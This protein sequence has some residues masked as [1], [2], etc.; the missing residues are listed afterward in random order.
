VPD[1]T[2]EP[3]PAPGADQ[4]LAPGPDQAPDGEVLEFAAEFRR[5]LDWVRSSAAGADRHNEVSALVRGFLGPDGVEHSVVNRD[6]PPFEHVNLQ[7]AINAWLTRPGRT[8]EIR[9]ISV[10]PHYGGLTLQQLVAQD[11]LP[12][13]RLTAPALADLPNGPGSTLACLKL[14]VLLITDEP[15]GG[16]PGGRYVVMIQAQSEHRPVIEVEVAGLPVAAAQSLLAELDRLRAELNVYRGHLL[17]VSLSAMGGISLAF[18]DPP[19]LVREDVV[20]PATVLARVERHA[21]G[22]A[23]HRDALLAAGQHL[24]RGLL[25]YG[26]PGTGKTHTTRYLLGQMN[27]YTR[28]VLTGRSLVAVGQVADLARALVPAVVVLE[29][30]D[31]VA[32]E[33]SM[34]PASSPVL[35]DLLDAMDGAAPDA[36]VL[37]LL[38]TNRADL[39]ESA[40]AA[41]PGRVDVA[42]E[43]ALPD[44]PARQRLL[45]LYSRGVPM[46][47]TADEVTAAVERTDGTTA[48]FIKELIR[49]SVLEALHDNPPRQVPAAGAPEPGSAAAGTPAS[50]SPAL[51]AVTGAHLTRALDDL[52]DT[53]QAVTRTLLGVGVNPEDLPAGGALAAGPAASSM[54]AMMARRAFA[55]RGWH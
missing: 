26:P 34:G 32:Q 44:A 41:R 40:L 27:D 38:T 52:L 33:R 12:P 54:Q 6:L 16:S 15:L 4:A 50:G 14:A 39:L 48:S 8:A 13:V 31:L 45:A 30:V 3:G 1:Q 25:L 5:F 35:F 42:V 24:K 7:T 49:R 19:G 51:T 22:V 43:I 2:Q 18:S 29:D 20:L 37:F 11:G 9:G 46:A 28:L 17:D 53:A 47:L 55:A 23:A 10:P 36:D 21:L